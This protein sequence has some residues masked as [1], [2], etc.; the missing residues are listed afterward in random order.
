MWR[1]LAIIASV[2]V[3]ATSLSAARDDASAAPEYRQ[4]L[5]QLG[6]WVQIERRGWASG[7]WQGELI[8]NFNQVDAVVGHTY[9]EEASLQLDAMKALGITHIT[10]ELRTADPAT[11]PICPAQTYPSCQVCYTLGLDWP[12]P[13]ATEL[14]NLKAFLDLIASKKMKLDLLLTTTHMDEKP[15]VNGKKWLGA[16]FNTIEGHPALALVLFGGDA[17]TIDTNGDG[18]PDACGG[19]GGE[20]PLWLGAKSYAAT[21]LQWVIPFAIAHGISYS[22]LSAEAIVGDYFLDSQ[23]PAGPSATDHHLWKPISVLKGIFDTLKVPAGSRTYAASFY[24]H[25]KCATAQSL[26]CTDQDPHDW[27]ENRLQD[28][29]AVIGN[30]QSSRLIITEGGTL[31]PQTWP[32]ERSFESLGFL[33]NKYNTGGGNFWRW[34]DFENSEETSNTVAQA[35]KKRGVA[36]VYLPPEKEVVDLGGSHLTAIPNGSFES[37][38]ARPAQWAITGSGT[39]SRYHLAGERKQP[40]VPSR[41]DY[42]LRLVTSTVAS[43]VIKATSALIAVN[44]RRTYTTTANLRFEW[45]G[46]PNPGGSPLHRPQVFVTFNYLQA[47]KKPSAVKASDTFRYFQENAAINFM[48]FPMQYTTPADAAYVRIVIGAA[49]NGLPSAITLDADNLR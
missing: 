30:A 16:I 39:A 14:T 5:R 18:V 35:V 28:A 48:T 27:A 4:V 34:T 12:T 33:M 45:T 49:R 1:R 17:H 37:G 15:P 8:Q 36:Y 42:D 38:A 9:G 22:Q 19:Q 25:T 6:L 47:N 29:L 23:A 43:A 13:T 26:P 2:G 11:A 21:Y 24:E 40:L 3:L 10:Y 7:Y 41:G 31:A 46:D 44:A 32:A 20:A